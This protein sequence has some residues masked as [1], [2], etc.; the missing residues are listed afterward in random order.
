M[1]Y[2]EK[3]LIEISRGIGELEGRLNHKRAHKS[4]LQLITLFFII[5]IFVSGNCQ[6]NYR[7]AKCHFLNFKSI[8]SF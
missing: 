6:D 2:N 4:G 3:E 8:G 5:I 7:F 1:K